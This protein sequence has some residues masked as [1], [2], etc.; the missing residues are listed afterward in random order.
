M[1]DIIRNIIV[2]IILFYSIILDIIIVPIKQQIITA[3][4]LCVSFTDFFPLVKKSFFLPVFHAVFLER[5]ILHTAS[6]H[7]SYLE[8]NRT[9][10]AQAPWPVGLAQQPSPSN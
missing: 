10:Q 5:I 6:K 9:K 3:C 4:T 2:F 7:S 1:L 8:Q